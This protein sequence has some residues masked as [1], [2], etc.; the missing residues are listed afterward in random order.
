MLAVVPGF[1][2]VQPGDDLGAIIIAGIE[3][4]RLSVGDGDVIVM[5]QKVVSKAQGRYVDL[6][7]IVP[8]AR[9]QEIAVE[10]EKDARLVE[11]ILAESVAR[12]AQ[13]IPTC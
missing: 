13:S 5:A 12:G 4:A 8:S 6:A 11:L 7:T 10:V 3:K 2:L 9:A 1:P